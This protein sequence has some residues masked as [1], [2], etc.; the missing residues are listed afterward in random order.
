MKL[1][2]SLL[3]WGNGSLKNAKWPSSLSRVVRA[4]AHSEPF[5]YL[6]PSPQALGFQKPLWNV[7]L[8]RPP[9]SHQYRWWVR[10][11]PEWVQ[12]WERPSHCPITPPASAGPA[13]YLSDF[14]LDR[15]RFGARERERNT[16]ICLSKD[17]G[18][19]WKN[20]TNLLEFLQEM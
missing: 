3:I 5:L 16:L 13:Q 14:G 17:I 2:S 8:G 4:R 7:P 11:L 15:A 18:D 12:P 10:P 6:F 19:R 20:A 9:P 1:L